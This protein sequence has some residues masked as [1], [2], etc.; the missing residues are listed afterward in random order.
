MSIHE[1]IPIDFDPFADRAVRS[2]PLTPAQTEMWAATQFGPEASCSLNQCFVLSLRGPV[3]SE[4]MQRALQTVVNRHESLR[5]TFEADGRTQIVADS[6]SVSLQLLDLSSLTPERRAAEIERIVTAETHLPFNLEAGPVF[7]AHLVHEASDCS[8]LIFTSSHIVC[9][10]WSSS[11]LFADLARAY[12]ADRLGL[13]APLPAA[14]SYCRYVIDEV[15]TANGIASKQDEDYWLRQYDDATPVL[16]LPLDRRRPA[17]RTFAG[18]RE[19]LRLDE[20]LCKR[21]KK[22]G[23]SRGSTLFVTL[24]ATFEVLL[25]R[26]SGQSDFV[27]GIPIAG[28]PRLENG[29]LVAHCV[30]TLP[31]RCRPDLASTFADHLKGVREAFLEAQ[32]HQQVTFGSLVPK[33][34]RELDPSRP[35]LVAVTFNIDRLGAK[36]DFGDVT[37][38][39]IETPKSFVIFE[40]AIN[41]VDS[42]TD[43]IV[44]CE[45]NT[46]LFDRQS[47]S[48]WLRHYRVLLEAIDQD[49]DVKLANIPL[50]ADAERRTI[51][52][53]WNETAQAIP[54]AHLD[55]AVRGAGGE[56]AGCHRG[57]VWGT[58]A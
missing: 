3:S 22:A 51:L 5:T 48:R 11:V 28:Q 55:G 17:F 43:L 34:R 26:L 25:C 7:R 6:A 23:A 21:I 36:F 27:V 33:L 38:D 19:V 45:Y 41:I 13:E 8:R 14:S 47:I 31:L 9:D 54:A 1:L 16:D 18:A 40:L 53:E 20:A 12:A 39:S 35:P 2:L 56:K 49:L 29:H 32:A 10:G 24:L 58:G 15:A 37:L 42:G 52:E 30:N 46:D 57:D 4:S 50:L 44:E